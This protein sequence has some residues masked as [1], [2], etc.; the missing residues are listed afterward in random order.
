MK[1]KYTLT[2]ET[3]KAEWPTPNA[4]AAIYERVI[5]RAI[6]DLYAGGYSGGVWFD[7]AGEWFRYARRA[8]KDYRYSISEMARAIAD[9][10]AVHVFGNADGKVTVR[11]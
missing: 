3:I 1:T 8:G 4:N 5:E 11:Q 9:G 6:I 10:R 2:Q 7:F